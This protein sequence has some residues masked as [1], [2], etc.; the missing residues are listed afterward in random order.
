MG[1][2]AGVKTGFEAYERFG[3]AGLF[4]FVFLVLLF[5]H[6]YD[7]RRNQKE[8]QAIISQ[9]TTAL[10]TVAGVVSE[11]ARSN[12]ELKRSVDANTQANTIMLSYLEGRDDGG[13]GRGTSQRR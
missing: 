6:F 13:H 4:V 11:N 12:E 1:A 9:T 5:Y 7:Q 8:Y 3:F 10:E 2:E